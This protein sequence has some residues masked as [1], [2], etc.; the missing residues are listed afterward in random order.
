MQI[1][2]RDKV[3]VYNVRKFHCVYVALAVAGLCVSGADATP[4]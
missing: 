1:A 2:G 3:F 4:C